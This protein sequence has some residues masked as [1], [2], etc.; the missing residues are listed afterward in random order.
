MKIRSLTL[1]EYKTSIIINYLLLSLGS[2]TGLKSLLPGEI[3][4]L[5]LVEVLAE[6]AAVVVSWEIELSDRFFSRNLDILQLV[7]T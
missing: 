6:T 5:T 3:S 1:R 4:T 2:L 7:P